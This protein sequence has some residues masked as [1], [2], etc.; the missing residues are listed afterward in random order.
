MRV[1]SGVLIIAFFWI[2]GTAFAGSPAFIVDRLPLNAAI[3]LAQEDVFGRQYVLPPELASDTRPVTLD[4]SLAGDQKTQREEYVRWLR[5]MNIAVETRNGVDHYRS[6]KPVAA[7]EKMVS[8]YIRRYIDRRPI[9]PRCF[10]EQQGA[11]RRHLL[12]VRPV[13]LRGRY[14]AVY[15]HHQVHF[16]RVRVIHWFSGGHVQSWR[17]L[18]SW[19]RWSMFRRRVLW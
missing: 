13:R 7:P 17:V 12:R 5:Q 15:R 9:L 10:R 2:S 18:R 6:F 1:F 8:W 11:H 4:L 16:Y 19:S 14:P 3:Q